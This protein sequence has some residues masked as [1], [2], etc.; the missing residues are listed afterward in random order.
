MRDQPTDQ[1][2]NSNVLPPPEP[3]P[4]LLSAYHQ[5]EGLDSMGG[6][7]SEPF[8]HADCAESASDTFQIPGQ[9]G[10]YLRL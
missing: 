1:I 10:F 4:M 5:G 7:V 6:D 8:V 9:Q 3:T 2:S